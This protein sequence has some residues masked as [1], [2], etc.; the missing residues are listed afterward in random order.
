M[1]CKQLFKDLNVRLRISCFYYS[2]G[3]QNLWRGRLRSTTRLILTHLMTAIQVLHC[4]YWFV[5]LPGPFPLYMIPHYMILNV[6]FWIF[7][8]SC[9]VHVFRLAGRANPECMLGH[10]LKILFKNDDFMNAVRDTWPHIQDIH[11]HFSRFRK[12]FAAR[13]LLKYSTHL[14][15][16]VQ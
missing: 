13:F 4:S 15:K 12:L 3:Y 2:P 5:V 6:A 10:L 8:L 11:C 16:C 9:F 1:D 7:T 14:F